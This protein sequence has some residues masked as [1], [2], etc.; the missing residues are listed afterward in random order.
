MAGPSFYQ[1]HVPKFGP[2]GSGRRY[3]AGTPITNPRGG[4]VRRL[5]FPGM[6]YTTIENRYVVGAGVGSTNAAARRALRRRASTGQNGRPCGF[7]CPPRFAP[8]P[9]PPAPAPET[10]PAPATAQAPATAPPAP[11]QAPATAPP[12]P[13]Q[14]PAPAPAP[15]SDLEELYKVGVESKSLTHS[16]YDLGSSLA[17]TMNGEQDVQIP[18]TAGTTLVFDLSDTALSSH[19]FVVST[20]PSG[21]VLYPA[22]TLHGTMGTE[23]AELHVLLDGSVETLYYGC[24]LHVGMGGLINILV[25]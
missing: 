11:A 7:D 9:A 17:Y 25:A 10:A 22:A 18:A 16:K 20:N 21:T 19:P 1:L 4:G 2:S 23:D 14:A 24:G 6:S 15:T 3:V 8:H 12:A 5:R 13:A